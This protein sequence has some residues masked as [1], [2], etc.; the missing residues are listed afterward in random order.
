KN[1]FDDI[2]NYWNWNA[3]Y[4]RLTAAIKIA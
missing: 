2:Q 3:A 1:A 4:N